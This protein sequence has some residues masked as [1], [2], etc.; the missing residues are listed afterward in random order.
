MEEITTERSGDAQQ[1]GVEPSGSTSQRDVREHSESNPSPT[2]I[3]KKTRGGAKLD[4]FAA[5]P[6]QLK[7]NQLVRLCMVK[8]SI[9]Q[10]LC[11]SIALVY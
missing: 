2:T 11:L 4:V 1:H 8:K 7:I 10:N 6:F 3:L 5:L 9:A